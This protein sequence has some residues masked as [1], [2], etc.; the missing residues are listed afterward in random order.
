MN[1]HKSAAAL[2][3]AAL[4]GAL[5]VGVSG[6]AAA[7][8]TVLPAAGAALSA[9]QQEVYK[10]AL[11]DVA[12]TADD[13]LAD[14]KQ[15]P[16]DEAAY[17]AAFADALAVAGPEDELLKSALSALKVQTDAL[18][19]VVGAGPGGV[20]QLPAALVG[21]TLAIQNVLS[22]GNLGLA[23]GALLKPLDLKSLDLGALDLN[24]LPGGDKL[25]A[26]PSFGDIF[27]L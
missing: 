17:R 12:I 15:G 20:G 22:V 2:V 23:V 16:V 27:K 10:Q 26:L 11:Q 21:V 4:A 13:L 9:S 18:V 25:P 5:V 7:A 24:K 3:A 1:L 6:T 14:A 8:P 19:K